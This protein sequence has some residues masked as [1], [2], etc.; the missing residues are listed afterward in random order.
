MDECAKCKGFSE[1]LDLETPGEYRAIAGKL[2][3]VVDQRTFAIVS[4]DCPLED[5]FK[6]VWPSDVVEHKFFCVACGRSYRLFA[7]TY[8]GRAS[9]SPVGR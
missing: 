8:H 1:R 2:I 7:D 5:L 3:E 4:A 9:W 6:P